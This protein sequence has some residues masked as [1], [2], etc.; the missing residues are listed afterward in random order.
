MT[1]INWVLVRWKGVISPLLPKT[2]FGV[3]WVKCIHHYQSHW[4]LVVYFSSS[5]LLFFIQTFGPKIWAL[6]IFSKHS[7]PNSVQ[8]IRK[9]LTAGRTYCNPFT[10]AIVTGIRVPF[11]KM[12]KKFSNFLYIFMNFTPFLKIL[13]PCIH[14]LEYALVGFHNNVCS[15][16]AQ[17]WRKYDPYWDSGSFSPPPPPPLY[18]CKSD[19]SEKGRLSIV[20][21]KQ[22]KKLFTAIMW[23]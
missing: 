21:P 20:N 10:H 14:V 17:N 9:I 19:I 8:N 18:L 5:S 13:P 23:A 2:W 15:F 16:L 12:V 4:H 22:S 6:L 7:L 11:S 3:I 1:W